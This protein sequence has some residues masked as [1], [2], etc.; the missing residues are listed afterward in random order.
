MAKRTAA[1]RR[2]SALK[3]ARTRKRNAKGHK[4]PARK[5]ARKRGGALSAEE[6][7]LLEHVVGAG[8]FS[9]L[10]DRIKQ[11]A[12][13]LFGIARPH[14]AQFIESH[15]KPQIHGFVQDQVA[16]HA[17]K[18]KAAARAQ[19]NALRRRT[20]AATRR[21]TKRITGRGMGNS[22]YGPRGGTLRPA[23]G[24]AIPLREGG[25]LY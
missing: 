7:M 3:G 22:L 14:A 12:V 21:A 10:K 1:Q 17:P 16:R 2:A 25:M 13:T 23:G 8:F 6:R 4:K 19:V 18:F 15:V 9:N 24:S 20:A 11:A 5:K